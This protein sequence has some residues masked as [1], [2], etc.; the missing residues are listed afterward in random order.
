MPNFILAEP[1]LMGP[2]ISFIK[3]TKTKYCFALAT[4]F[5]TIF[6]KTDQARFGQKVSRQK[7]TGRDKVNQYKSNLH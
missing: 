3:G 1:P 7:I 5:A 6:Y 2:L 4:F